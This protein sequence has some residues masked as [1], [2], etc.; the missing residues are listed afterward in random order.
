M[1]SEKPQ[2]QQQHHRLI[3]AV[4]IT[5]ILSVTIKWHEIVSQSVSQSYGTRTCEL[6]F[7]VLFFNSM[8]VCEKKSARDDVWHELCFGFQWNESHQTSPPPSSLSLLLLLLIL[9][10]TTAAIPTKNNWFDL[11]CRRWNT[12]TIE[13]YGFLCACVRVLN[14]VECDKWS[15]THRPIAMRTN[16]NHQINNEFVHILLT[17]RTCRDIYGLF[18][19]QLLQW[20]RKRYSEYQTA[21]RREK[22]K[23]NNNNSK[24]NENICGFPQK[25][26]KSITYSMNITCSTFGWNVFLCVVDLNLSSHWFKF[27]CLYCV[28]SCSFSRFISRFF[29]F[30]CQ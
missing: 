14:D 21:K 28:F 5:T 8:W 7:M 23:I 9:T 3:Y 13:I 1:S 24:I 16:W 11:Y 19:Q 4:M 15:K 12:I 10:S 30:F 6:C 29:L 17:E 18:T 25:Q 22:E 27:I 20:R 2:R 26:K